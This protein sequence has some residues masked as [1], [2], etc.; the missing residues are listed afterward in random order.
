[1]LRMFKRESKPSFNN[2]IS[3]EVWQSVTSISSEEPSQSVQFNRNR[4]KIER[5]SHRTVPINA[6]LDMHSFVCRWSECK[7]HHI[8]VE[9]IKTMGIYRNVF[10]IRLAQEAYEKGSTIQAA[11]FT[12]IGWLIRSQ[13]TVWLR[14]YQLAGGP[15]LSSSLSPKAFAA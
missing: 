8:S 7:V 9:G 5:S 6:L 15:L 12:S 10:Y 1:M 14:D 13:Q 4:L 2:L 3:M 11:R